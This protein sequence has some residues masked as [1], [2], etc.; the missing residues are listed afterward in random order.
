MSFTAIFINLFVLFFLLVSF[1]KDRDRTKKA[2]TLGGKSFV[3]IFPSVLVIIMLIGLL[4]G[5]LPE[6]K[7]SAFVGTQSGLKG[8]FSIAILG[9]VLQIPSILSFPLAASLLDKGAQVS[10]VAVFLTTLT[11]IGIIILPLEIKVMGK[12]FALLRNGISFIIAVV[13]AFLMGVIL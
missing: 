6:S 12:K 11:M 2:L 5:L 10:S 4:L 1:L 9:S 3:K 7:I 8:F 13:I